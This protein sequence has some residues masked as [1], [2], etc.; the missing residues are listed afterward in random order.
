[1]TAGSQVRGGSQREEVLEATIEE[2][3]FRSDDGH[4]VVARAT[5]ARG[6][7]LVTAV[8]DLGRVTP[9]ETLR[10]RGRWTTHVTYGRRFSVQGFTPVMPTTQEGVARYLGS[11]LVPGVGPSLAKRLVARFGERSLDVITQQSAKLREVDGIG[12]RRAQ[13]IAQAVRAR[14]AEAESMSYLHGLGLGPAMGRRILRKYGD[15]SVRVLREDPYRVAEEVPGIGFRTADR[16]GQAAGIPADDPRRAAGAVLHLLGKG[17]D[18]GHVY[19]T[20]EQLRTGAE[21]LE[22]PGERAEEVLEPLVE[23]GLAVADGEAIYAP[24]LFRAEHRVAERLRSLAGARKPRRDVKPPGAGDLTPTQLDSVHA[25]LRHGLMVLT[26]GPG[27]GKTTTVRAI[28]QAH[29]AAEHRVLLCAPTGR[30][31]KRLSEATG[32]EASTIHRLLEWSPFPGGF[33]RDADNPLDAELVLV[34]EASMLDLKLA[35]SLLAAVPPTSRLVLV[36][37]VDQ[38]PPVGAGQVL[39]DLIDS[40]IAHVVR[41]V[42]V[43]RQARRSAIVRGAHQILHGRLPEPTPAGE[44]GDGDLF[45]VRSREPD[46]IVERLISSLRRL[47]EAYGLDPKTDAMVLTPMRRG[48]LGT[49]QLNAVLQGELNPAARPGT[50][51]MRPGDKVMQLRN[52]YDKEVFNGDLGE[53]RRVEGGVTFVSIDGREVQYGTEDRD[54]LTL[55]YASTVHKVQGSEFPAVIVVLHG[56]HHVLLSRSLLYTAVTRAR[57][58]VVLV[59]DERAMAR[60]ARNAVSLRCNSRLIDRLKG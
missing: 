15:A 24:P 27:T 55:A 52:D 12:P 50:P 28:V 44:K 40:G 33:K 43:F 53:V 18:D 39:R 25:S 22:V 30:A 51:A 45:L 3:V 6:D 4:F 32:Y 5:P 16:I 7:E 20:T 13:A 1:M 56:S 9:G 59:G 23:R 34:D 19:L 49:E 11:G 57:R 2:I 31:A 14:R 48:P 36:G 10:L 37:D 41:L 26:G 58:L 29:R 46:A 42:E 21:A 8:G 47:P 17:A 38:L 54:A 35:E 60:A